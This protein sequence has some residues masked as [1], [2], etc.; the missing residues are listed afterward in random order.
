MFLCMIYVLMS[1]LGAME[2]NES[3]SKKIKP[4]RTKIIGKIYAAVYE[5]CS[6]ELGVIK[7]QSCAQSGYSSEPWSSLFTFVEG[8]LRNDGVAIFGFA[9]A[10]G[11]IAIFVGDP[12]S[13][14]WE[15]V[16]LK[17]M[18]GCR[19]VTDFQVNSEGEIKY[20]NVDG[21]WRLIKFSK[22]EM[23]LI[24]NGIWTNNLDK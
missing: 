21:T 12:E 22:T 4:I 17:F 10:D 9:S 24:R 7:E 16:A 5:D 18:S 23:N 1:R 8:Y 6:I 2:Q 19:G 14:C 11:L 20:L 13:N 3:I 15:R